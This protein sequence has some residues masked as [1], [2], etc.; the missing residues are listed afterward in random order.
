[1]AHPHRLGILGLEPIPTLNFVTAIDDSARFRSS[2]KVSAYFV[3]TSERRQSDASLDIKVNISKAGDPE[4]RCALY[5]AA[6]AKLTGFK[7][8]TAPKNWG[9]N[10]AKGFVKSI[11][12]LAKLRCVG[13]RN[14]PFSQA[15][16][17]LLSIQF[18]T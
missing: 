17:P 9:L 10:I 8:T 6:S 3:L 4:V 14:G 13:D 16:D 5:E 1:M 18:I 11:A 15:P 2:R 12:L 7:G